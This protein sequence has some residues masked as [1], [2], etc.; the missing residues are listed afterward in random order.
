[1]YG[2]E[3]ATL[4]G[5]I[6]NLQKKKLGEIKNTSDAWWSETISQFNA[7]ADKAKDDDAKTC[8]GYHCIAALNDLEAKATGRKFKE[9]LNYISGDMTLD[10]FKDYL[11]VAKTG[12]SVSVCGVRVLVR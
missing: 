12:D 8:L 11:E 6:W 1:M 3:E 10:Q 5:E 9:S 7:I 2:K 4:M